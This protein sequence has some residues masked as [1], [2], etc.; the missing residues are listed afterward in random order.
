MKECILFLA[1][2]FV[3]ISPAFAGSANCTGTTAV[4]WDQANAETAYGLSSECVVRAYQSDSGVISKPFELP[5]SPSSGDEFTLQ[6]DT[7]YSLDLCGWYFD[8][9]EYGGNGNSY[10]VCSPA[11]ITARTTTSA[12]IGGY[13]YNNSWSL[14]GQYVTDALDP[15]N[16]PIS[17]PEGYPTQRR[18]QLKL[19]YDSITNDW[20]TTETDWR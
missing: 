16:Q 6:D 5:V 1:F 15:Q 18:Q 4:S 13:E 8:D 11:G 7:P 3:L 10:R 20:A 2:L 12:T 9:P 14:A 17:I 19:V